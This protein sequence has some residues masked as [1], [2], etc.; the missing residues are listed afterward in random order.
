LKSFGERMPQEM[1]EEH[2]NLAQRVSE[3]M[4]PADLHGR[5]VGH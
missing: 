3:A 2:A 5:D 4:T 1:I